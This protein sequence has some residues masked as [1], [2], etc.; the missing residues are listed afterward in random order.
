MRKSCEPFLALERIAARTWPGEEVETMGEWLVRASRGVT[1]RANSVLAAGEFP[2]D[3]RWLA[4]IERFYRERNLPALFHVS[5]ASPDG[6]DEFLGEN[7]YEKE[8][9]CLL[10]TAD[11]REAA[12]KAQH[13]L[14]GTKPI[15]AE[16]V[17][18]GQAGEQWTRDF[19][20]LEQFPAE[21]KSFYD[22]LFE[23]MPGRKGFLALR[24]EGETVALGTAI[25]RNGWAGFMNVVV[26]EDCRGQGLGL[27]LMHAMTAWSVEQGA[28]NQF[29]QVIADNEQANRLYEKLGYKPLFGYH[30]RVKYELGPAA[31]S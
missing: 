19:I 15:A 11:S 10:M 8:V 13:A 21:R 18:S 23:R 31:S 17:W 1:K 27:L 20:R 4:R 6:L 25:A 26:R 2:Q 29:L 22:G 16:I 3:G 30:Y 7:G 24:R 14:G 12:A 9:P 28:D 5:D